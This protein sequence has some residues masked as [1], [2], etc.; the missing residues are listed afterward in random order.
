[1]VVR[2]GTDVSASLIDAAGNLKI[3]G[4]AGVGVDNIDIEAATDAGVIVANAPEANTVAAAEHALT[5]LLASAR[6]VSQA[7]SDLSEETGTNRSTSE[8]RSEERRSVSSGSVESAAKSRDARTH[9][10]WTS[11]RTIR[12]SARNPS[13]A[14]VVSSVRS[15]TSSNERT[16]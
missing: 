10:A 6:N 5:L 1:M 9:S 3:V 8:R 11:S 15:T 4:R 7:D 16:S 14:S 2:S 12:S 13:K